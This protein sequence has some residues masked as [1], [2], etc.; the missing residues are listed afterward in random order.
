MSH[1]NMLKVI[2][3]AYDRN[4]SGIAPY[5]LE[6]AKLASITFNVTM[7]SFDALDVNENIDVITLRRPGFP[8]YLSLLNAKTSIN[9]VA[10]T[11][12]HADPDIVHE[13]IPPLAWNA[14]NLITTRWG[15]VSYSR[16]AAIRTLQMQFPYNLG[17][18]PVTMQHYLGDRKS[19]KNAKKIIDISRDSEDFLPPPFPMR[20][21]KGDTSSDELKLLFVAR[22]INMRRKNL[23]VLINAAK[24]LKRKFTLHVVGRG[25]VQ[26]NGIISHGHLNNNEV[27]KLMYECDALVLPSLYEELG[28]VGM[29]AY[30]LGLPVI[31]SE[32]PSFKTVLRRSIFFPPL[33]HI[34][35]AYLLENVSQ[36]H[37]RQ[38]GIE[39]HS[40]A[41]QARELI[42]K[43]LEDIYKS[44][45]ELG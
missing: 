8:S 13:T 24:M 21:L 4:T 11:I 42:R 31:A 37:L 22:D 28:F 45:L 27:I 38:V 15:Y 30:S 44:V 3:V 20:V 39:S 5:T 35:L 12:K 1:K 23:G 18:I 26:G 10:I 41:M 32:I 2:F 33:D 14:N 43:G 17:G 34:R 6:I 9:D 25:H 29:E 19:F 36:E 16:L 40:Y 7:I